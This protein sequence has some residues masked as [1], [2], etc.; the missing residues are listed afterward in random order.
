MAPSTLILGLGNILMTDEAVGAAVL[1]HLE[2]DPSLPDDWLLLDGGTLSFTLAGPIGDAQRLIVVDAAAMGDAPGTVR[3]FE[4]E[5]MDRQLRTHA[6][7]VHEVSLA[8]LMDMVRLTDQLPAQR[9]LIGIEP[10]QIGWGEELTPPVATAVPRASA[11]VHALYARWVDTSPPPV[12]N[13][14]DP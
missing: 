3:I 7:S 5:A 6:K 10:E 4:G 12:A 9:A 14:S 11:E 1:K 8:D 13:Q 2:A